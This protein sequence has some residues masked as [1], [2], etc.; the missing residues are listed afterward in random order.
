M[1]KICLIG[2]G[3]F[4]C[5]YFQAILKLNLKFELTIVDTLATFNKDFYKL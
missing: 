4:G 3:N 5:R 2:F 1:S